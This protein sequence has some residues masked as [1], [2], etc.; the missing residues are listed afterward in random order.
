M[1][2]GLRSLH[3]LISV[4]S[5]QDGK[6]KNISI[7]YC[8][9]KKTNKRIEYNWNRCENDDFKALKTEC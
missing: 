2:F 8:L 4:R 6:H 1:P 5:H 9:M 7:Y 3:F